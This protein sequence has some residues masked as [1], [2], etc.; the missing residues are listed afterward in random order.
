VVLLQPDLR[1]LSALAGQ[2]RRRRRGR[3]SSGRRVETSDG[4]EIASSKSRKPPDKRGVPL[5]VSWFIGSQ[6]LPTPVSK[7]TI[8]GGLGG[9]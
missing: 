7:S 4:N 8:A 3:H 5:S 2:P 6:Q 9:G 1:A